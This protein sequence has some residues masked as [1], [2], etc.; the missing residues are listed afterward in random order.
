M[1]ANDLLEVMRRY[2]FS[3]YILSIVQEYMHVLQIL[4]QKEPKEPEVQ[5]FT[6][7]CRFPSN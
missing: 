6:S 2:L 5:T 7:V 4:N 3:L 1:D